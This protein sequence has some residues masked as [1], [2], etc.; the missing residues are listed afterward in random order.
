MSRA[1]RLLIIGVL[2][3]IVGYAIYSRR[4]QI[5]SK[6]W[7]W[8]HGY[9]AAV[10]DYV[11]PVPD[12]WLIY[13]EGP[14]HQDLTMFDTQVKRQ[15][16]PLLVPN[17]ITVM[18]LS[19]PL[20]SLD[21]WEIIKRKQLEQDGLSNIEERTLFTANEKLVCLGG[22]QLREVLKIPGATHLTLECQST[23][24]LSLIYMGYR[25][26]LDDFYSIASQI[27]KLN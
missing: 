11:V 3:L 27:R 15:P 2:V 25:S 8:K 22:Y 20:R 26:G 16:G 19:A 1:S 14:D 23:G 6:V 13:S 9:S 7:H 12:R 24:R 5:E 10:G 21:S 4:Y 18:S 17:M